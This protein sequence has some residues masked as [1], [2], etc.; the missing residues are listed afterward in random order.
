[1]CASPS[2]EA[3]A[4]SSGGES[5]AGVSVRASPEEAELDAGG[6]WTC[7]CSRARIAETFRKEHPQVVV[8]R[9]PDPRHLTIYH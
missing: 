3:Y 4:W 1:M 8:D 6:S 7:D 2:L 9:P 5:F